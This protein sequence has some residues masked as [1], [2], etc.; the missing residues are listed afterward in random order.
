MSFNW[1]PNH[2][3][4]STHYTQYCQ[5]NL[6]IPVGNCQI[7]TAYTT[8]FKIESLLTDQF[9]ANF[10]FVTTSNKNLPL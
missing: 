7:P 2:P 10:D 5:D 1:L 3:L 9:L 4:I 8:K 6:T